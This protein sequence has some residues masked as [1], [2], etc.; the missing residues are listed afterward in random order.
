MQTASAYTFGSSG[1]D[2]YSGH[3]GADGRN[4]PTITLRAD[5]VFKH[6]DLRGSEG[7]DGG[8]G[9]DGGD[10]YSCTQGQPS[11]DLTGASGGDGGSGGKAGDGGSGGNTLVYYKNIKDLSQ[12]QIFNGGARG[13]RSGRSGDGGYG[14]NCTYSNWRIEKCHTNDEDEQ[15]CNTYTY[16]CT[17]GRDGRRG[18]SPSDGA[19]GYRGSISIVKDLDVLPAERPYASSPLGALVKPMHFSKRIWQTKAGAVS[20]FAP[21]SSISDS[22]SEYVRLAEKDFQLVWKVNRDIVDF[23]GINVSLGYDGTNINISFAEGIFYTGHYVRTETLD[24]YVVTQAF[25]PSDLDKLEF[26][27]PTGK[28]GDLAIGIK[29]NA[30]LYDIIQTEVELKLTFKRHLIGHKIEFYDDVPKENIEMTD[31]LLNISLG[32][33][34]GV[35]TKKFK[36]KRKIFVEAIVT[37]TFGGR[38]ITKSLSLPEYKIP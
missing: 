14:C 22:Y 24:Q 20:L 11:H 26:T 27:T 9:Q 34:P 33:L 10:A 37:R 6:Y 1:S 19:N 30:D 7:S 28:E 25:L 31:D 8:N 13:G 12:I 29:D 4:G 15:V 16:T 18:I 21:G 38:S 17:D 36:N 32:K 23:S 3:S 5:G 2:G 35:R